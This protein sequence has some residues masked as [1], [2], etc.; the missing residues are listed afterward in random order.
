[1]NGQQDFSGGNYGEK[2]SLWGGVRNLKKGN[3]K[4]SLGSR[5]IGAKNKGKNCKKKDWGNFRNYRVVQCKIQ[6]K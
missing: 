2:I 4:T 6:K 5:F 1:M 3:P